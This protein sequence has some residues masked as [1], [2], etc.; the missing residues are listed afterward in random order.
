MVF[1]KKLAG[2]LA[3]AAALV[4]A[5]AAV[6]APAGPATGVAAP[7]TPTSTSTTPS[8]SLDRVIC[9]Y[10]YGAAEMA[11]DEYWLSVDFPDV[12]WELP[13]GDDQDGDDRDDDR[14]EFNASWS[15]FQA[16]VQEYERRNCDDV[17]GR[18]APEWERR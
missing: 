15:A 10:W 9:L 4:L 16:A 11:N 3:A 14:D 17:L 12:E 6:A 1:S 8:S 18:P 2:A 7:A 5:P 13:G